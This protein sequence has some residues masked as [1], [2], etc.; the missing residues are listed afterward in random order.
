MRLRIV[1]LIIHS[2]LLI[3]IS[4][5][6]NRSPNETTIETLAIPTHSE[7]PLAITPLRTETSMPTM[8]SDER[9][10][11][12]KDLLISNSGCDLPCWWGIVPGVTKIKELESFLYGL[13]AKYS[14]YEESGANLYYTGGFDLDREGVFN[15]I[16]FQEIDGVVFAIIIDASGLN[17]SP[18]FKLVWKSFSPETILQRYGAPTRIWVSSISSVHEGTPGNTMPYSIWLFYDNLDVL[19][20]Y[21]GLVVYEN[22]YKMC[23]V[24]NHQGNLSDDIDIYLQSH[25]EENPLE[26]LPIVC[27][28]LCKISEDLAAD[29]G[30]EMLLKFKLRV[31][32]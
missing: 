9:A 16:A 11:Q 21:G 19:I 1:T 10:I 32:A 25:D 3:L 31:T 12:V 23:P 8:T 22:T 27:Q 17:N 26:N 6:T 20:R 13:G 4:G 28:W 15:N 2:V 5:C 29:A 18:N 7:T 30:T 14:L 24:F